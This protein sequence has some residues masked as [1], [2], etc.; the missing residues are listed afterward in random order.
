MMAWFFTKK[1]LSH[2]SRLKKFTMISIKTSGASALIYSSTTS[3]I[4][5]WNYTLGCKP[6]KKII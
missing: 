2:T 3:T 6:K 1:A 5:A 4:E